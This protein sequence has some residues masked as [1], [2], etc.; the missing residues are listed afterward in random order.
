VEP[1][2]TPLLAPAPVF[3]TPLTSLVV[4]HRYRVIGGAVLARGRIGVVTGPC[5]HRGLYPILLAGP[6]IHSGGNGYLVWAR[7]VEEV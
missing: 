7:E 5:N 4:G 2:P 6:P 3:K 1:N